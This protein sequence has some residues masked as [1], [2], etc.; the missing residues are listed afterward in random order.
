ML[1]WN[2]CLR[3]RRDPTIS[4]HDRTDFAIRTWMETEE[5][6]KTLQLHTC[7]I[8]RAFMYHG[9]EYLFKYVDRRTLIY[10]ELHPLIGTDNSTRMCISYEF[11]RF[12]PHV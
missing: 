6:E 1:L 7:G 4:D 2:A 3:V 12:V 8:E 10:S 11:Q 9:R 5:I